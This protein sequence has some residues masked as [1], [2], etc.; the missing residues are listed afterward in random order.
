MIDDLNRLVELR[1]QEM[2]S[3]AEFVAAKALLFGLVRTEG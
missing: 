3:E 1:Y 2:I